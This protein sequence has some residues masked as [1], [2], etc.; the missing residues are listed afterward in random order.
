[1]EDYT[2]ITEAQSDPEAA[3]D[4]SLIKRLRD[5]PIAI[6]KGAAGAPRVYARALENLQPGSEI[7]TREDAETSASA[8]FVVH[9]TR[10]FS[11]YGTFRF[12][13][14]HVNQYQGADQPGYGSRARIRRIRN[15]V[16]TTVFEQ[17]VFSQI[18]LGGYVVQNV[19]LVVRPGDRFILDHQRVG[20]L[21]S[22]MRNVRIQ[23]DGQDLWPGVQ[24]KLEGNRNAT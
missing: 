14:E 6:A 23:T 2:P 5:N 11:Q 12:R 16:T 20:F 21:S 19:D 10:D 18:G 7:R 17:T 24:A 8:G 15:N 13:F 22:L 1:M 9:M 3:V 4:S